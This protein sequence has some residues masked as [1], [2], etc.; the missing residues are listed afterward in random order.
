MSQHPSDAEVIEYLSEGQIPLKYW[1][2]FNGFISYWAPEVRLVMTALIDD[3]KMAAACR[4]FL[5]DRQASYSS[6]SEVAKAAVLQGW[7]N[8][9]KDE[10]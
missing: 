1:F 10:A 5:T 4:R 8:W 7:A 3:P 6:I 2:L 9:K